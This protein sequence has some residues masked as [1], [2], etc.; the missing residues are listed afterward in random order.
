M[1]DAPPPVTTRSRRAVLA[2]GLGAAVAAV[3]GALGRPSVARA[4]SDGD[5]VLG[6]DN[7]TGFITSITKTDDDFGGNAFAANAHGT[8]VAIIGNG[9]GGTG[10]KGNSAVATGYGVHAENFEGTAMYGRTNVFGQSGVLGE[11]RFG[12][13]V[14][15]Q[16]HLGDSTGTGTAGVWGRD[17]AASK[18]IGTYG[19]AVNGIGVY[20]RVASTANQNIPAPPSGN[21]A[22]LGE[23]AA[24][25]AVA[26]QASN[27]GG[28]AL[29]AFGKVHFSKSG[30]A[31]IAASTASI[32]VTKSGVTSSSLIWAMLAGNASGRWVR[33]VVAASGSFTIY[34]NTTVAS[35]TKVS[36]FIL[37]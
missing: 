18:G 36:W 4:G 2:A 7:Q 29:K 9:L 28:W 5:V 1:D 19:T 20:G 22:V 14:L 27:T 17:Y 8:G 21:I 33:A 31:T 6:Q 15:G 35:N 23:A 3:A 13:G 11:N 25:S 26:V 32:A 37:D 24:S 16:T 12:F 30:Q 34:L 10:I